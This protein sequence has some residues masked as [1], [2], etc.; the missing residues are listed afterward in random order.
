[1]SRD[2]T[3]VLFMSETTLVLDLLPRSEEETP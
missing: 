3:Y 2:N 1:M